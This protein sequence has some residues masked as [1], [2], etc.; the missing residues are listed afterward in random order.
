MSATVVHHSCTGPMD[1]KKFQNHPSPSNV[2]VKTL[3][4]GAEIGEMLV[5]T[6]PEV[7]YIEC[8]NIQSSSH[9]F[10]ANHMLAALMELFQHY[11]VEHHCD[12]EKG[13]P[14]L[15]VAFTEQGFRKVL[16]DKLG[17]NDNDVGWLY[18]PDPEVQV[19]ANIGE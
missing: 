9:R 5:C 18:Q 11:G 6:S 13:N 1:E 7:R 10:I 19:T 3:I 17:T 8:I 14:E 12:L 4:K 16:F 15:V 2:T